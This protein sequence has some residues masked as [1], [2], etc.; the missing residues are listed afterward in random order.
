VESINVTI[1]ENDGRK[2]KEENKES[3]EHYQEEYFK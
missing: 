1:D 3:M 2:I